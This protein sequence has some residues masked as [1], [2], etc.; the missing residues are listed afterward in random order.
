MKVAICIYR[1]GLNAARKEGGRRLSGLQIMEFQTVTRLKRDPLD[2]VLGRHRMLDLTNSHVNNVAIALQLNRRNMLLNSSV[3]RIRLNKCIS[4][5]RR[6]RVIRAELI[7][8]EPSA[9]HLKKLSHKE[10][11]LYMS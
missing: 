11:P 1:S 6:S 8:K 10:P 9:M 2:I 5:S 4:P 7:R 3:N